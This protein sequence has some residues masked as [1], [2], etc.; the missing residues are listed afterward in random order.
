MLQEGEVKLEKSVITLKYAMD[1]E[2]IRTARVDTYLSSSSDIFLYTNST[3]IHVY[4]RKYCHCAKSPA[5][6]RLNISLSHLEK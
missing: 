5:Q 3:Q 1:A 2:R 6:L 4:I